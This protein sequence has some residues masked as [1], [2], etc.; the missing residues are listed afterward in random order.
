M[1]R[2]PRSHYSAAILLLLGL[3]S[4]AFAQK[5]QISGTVTDSAG[6]TVAGAKLTATH[7]QTGTTQTTVTNG[8]GLY[9]LPQLQPGS[10]RLEIEQAGFRAVRREGIV[11]AVDQTARLDFALEPGSVNQTVE[12]T[13]ASP[14]VETGHADT[15]QVI[16]NRL[17]TEIPLNIRNP[18]FLLTLSP[19]VVT[20]PNFSASTTTQSTRN[21]FQADFRVGGGRSM[22]Q[23]VLLDGVADATSDRF[24]A[25]IP[26][27]DS[28]QEFKVQFNTYSAEYGR[29]TGGIINMIT[30]SGTKAFH[31][32]A[33]EFLRNSVFDAND[34]FSNRVGRPLKSFK[35][36]QFGGNFGGPVWLPGLYKGR[37][38]TFFFVAYEGLRQRSPNN[39]V[40]TVPTELQRQGDFSQTLTAAGQ[41]VVIYNPFST[42]PNPSG[43]GSLRDPFPGNRIPSS[44]LDPVALKLLAFYPLPNAS[45]APFTGVGNYVTSPSDRNDTDAV[46]VRADHVLS[47]NHRLFGRVSLNKSNYFTPGPFPNVASPGASSKL[48]TYRHVVLDYSW[49]VSPTSV[50]E[51][52][53]GFN[54]ARAQVLPA[55]YPFDFAD[56]GLNSAYASAA[57]PMFPS[58]SVANFSSLGGQSY[59]NQ[60]RNTYDLHGSYTTNLGRHFLKTGFNYRV[61]QLNSFQNDYSG[62][63]YSF[64]SNFTQGPDPAAAA[65]ATSGA[66][67]ASFLTGTP[68][69]GFI[70]HVS[71]LALQRL[72]YAGYVQ[73]DLKVTS[74]LTL[75]LGLRY[76]V[77]PGQTERY[78]R[79]NW[80]DLSMGSPIAQTAKRPDLKGGLVFAGNG[81]PRNQ[82]DTDWNNI[83]PRFGFAWRA[84]LSLVFRGGYGITYGPQFLWPVGVDGFNTQTTMVPTLDGFTPLNTLRNPYPQGFNL[85]SAAPN[86]LTDIGLPVVANL[87]N[88]RTPMIQQWSL[89]MQRELKSNLLLEVMYW[90]NKGQNLEVASGYELNYLPSQYF[91]LG[92][93]LN[94]LVDNPFYG[95]IT[96]GPLSAAKVSQRQLLLP[97]PQYTSMLRQV[98]DAASSIYHA[99]TIRLEQR[100]QAGLSLLA[101]YTFSKAISDADSNLRASDQSGGIQ[102]WENRRA[103]R[104]VSAFDV[105]HRFVLSG[106]YEL[107]FGKGK[108]FASGVNRFSNTVIGGWQL[109]LNAVIQS[110]LPLAVS[111]G[112]GPIPEFARLRPNSTGVSAKL[113]NPDINR[114]FNTAAFT[115]PAPYTF[116]N[117][118][119]LLPDVRRDGYSNL[120]AS[121]FKNFTVGDRFR[122]QF[123]YEVFNVLNHPVFGAPGGVLTSTNF[124]IVTSQAN[125]PRQMQLALKLNF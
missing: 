28:V 5:A 75:N 103:E 8:E 12:V 68:S 86:P 34:F 39:T 53:G 115:Q 47:Q 44:L 72:Y 50:V 120:D 82:F 19:G 90:A 124:G 4:P 117:V 105:P 2:L 118:G 110:G 107:P 15:G 45:G 46:D 35:R 62:G 11:L 6:G 99:G 73:D 10:W 71:A 91:S 58:L 125:A 93:G 113:D 13:A 106:S 65:S 17:V 23:E 122:A 70:T 111:A 29:T 78:N 16:E 48:D 89:S 41:P 32:T 56:L 67:L 81:Q 76:D 9:S 94:Q 102:N 54:R 108:P 14:L 84:P 18:L 1:P 61:L 40:S 33:Y 27:V 100:F 123:R 74:N 85:P 83:G 60:P 80:I 92:S 59:N 22:G 88:E 96:S 26:P 3:F 21:F 49:T 95:V 57:V 112:A 119:R 36:N 77:S 42:R 24:V 63:S 114:W 101:S 121:L 79:L 104:S 7:I 43:T 69:S 52:R 116:G 20:G 64:S 37:D 30:R 97:Y 109:N 51:L 38:K 98:P 66:A 25:L 55:S 31:G 87:R